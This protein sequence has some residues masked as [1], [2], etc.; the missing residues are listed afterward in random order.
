MRLD[1][2]FRSI[3]QGCG[4]LVPCSASYH[5]GLAAERR[6]AAFH[7]ER[8]HEDKSIFLTNQFFLRRKEFAEIICIVRRA[9]P[10]LAVF[11][12]PYFS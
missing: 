12:Q 11:L 4:V 2:I 10:R 7:A 5:G 6:K 8:G 9:Q 3:R 1:Y